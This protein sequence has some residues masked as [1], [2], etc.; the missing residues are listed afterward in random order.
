M[1]AY[2]ISMN[3]KPPRRHEKD[4][5]PE[6]PENWH[7]VKIIT[8]TDLLS[9]FPDDGA[10]ATRRKVKWRRVRHGIVL[11]VL[12]LALVAAVFVAVGISRGEIKIAAL[13][14]DPKPT[15]T[16][17]EGPFSY[18]AT[19]DVT[20][21]VYNSTGKDGLASSTS[22]ALKKR[23]FTIGAVDNKQASVEASTAVVVAGSEGLDEAFTVQRNIPGTTFKMDDRTDGSV[24]VMLGMSYK[25]L[26]DVKAI[27]KEPGALSC[28]HL[29][30]DP[31]PSTSTNPSTKAP[32]KP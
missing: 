27:S 9:A 19:K 4:P 7:G 23:G 11:I 13:Q 2:W 31:E 26:V 17:P 32:A 6:H 1:P 12:L 22:E 16:C 18:T 5:A 10:V 3:D 28:P 8:E 21:N 20:V 29:E 30:P 15:P 25:E 24:S 14:P